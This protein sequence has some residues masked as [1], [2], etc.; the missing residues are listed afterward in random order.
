MICM[1]ILYRRRKEV[2]VK[3]MP[4]V[5]VCVVMLCVWMSSPVN[6]QVE[7]GY[8]PATDDLPPYYVDAM[9]FIA[10]DSKKSR[11]D[12]FVQVGYNN[13]SF[14]KHND[15]YDASYEVSIAL[16]DSANS[17]VSE[18]LWTE[19]AKGVS[20]DKSVSPQYYSLT[21][22]TFEVAP[23][24]YVINT[25]VRDNE[26]KISR[27]QLK[28]I[29]V[30][31]YTRNDVSL[32]D[33]MLVL[34]LNTSGEKKSI[35]PSISPNLGDLNEP[36]FVFFESYNRRAGDTVRFVATVFDEAKQ[37][38][39]QADTVQ[40]LAQ[41]KGQVFMRIDHTSLPIGNYSL[42]IQL[43]PLHPPAGKEQ[44]ALATT[45]R[46]FLIRWGGV[47]NGIKDIDLAIDQLQYIA[48]DKEMEHLKEAT[49]P[50]EKQKRFVEFWKKRD[51]NPNT[52]RNEKMEE[53][54]AK[55]E[56]ANKNF[57]HYTDGWRTDMGMVYII[58]GP[59]SNVDRHPFDVDSKPFE[60]WSYYDLNHQFVF[61]DQSGFGDYRLTTPIWEV[62]QRPRD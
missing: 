49:T 42:Y 58:F 59:P 2:V 38:K 39:V 57:K 46:S 53:Y 22:R 52:P 48:K 40:A 37:K 30:P 33:I 29:V 12:V 61:V 60:V 20:F 4:G 45:S 54:Y 55:V 8:K 50:E 10:T 28:Q 31:D 17:L 21:E 36:F 25:I 27:R 51:P 34:K 15:L 19:D 16:L 32:S 43:F 35:V 26:T 13:L 9:S 62:W 23:G 3:I 7:L 1:G 47:A 56:F 24:R 41:G 14:V 5:Y 44:E 6:A 11:L 18:K